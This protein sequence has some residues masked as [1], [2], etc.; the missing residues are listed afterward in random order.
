MDDAIFDWQMKYEDFNV[1]PYCP[2]H[3][4]R[5][6]Q[7]LR[8]MHAMV[9]TNA[10]HSHHQRTAPTKVTAASVGMLGYYKMD[11]TFYC[12]WSRLV[13]ILVFAAKLGWVDGEEERVECAIH[14]AR[15]SNSSQGCNH[16]AVVVTVWATPWAFWSGF[17]VRTRV[18]LVWAF[19]SLQ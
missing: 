5:V 14:F 18:F 15:P 12:P 2:C 3:L 7:G 16:L 1:T 10:P 9:S 6:S 19:Q 13:A 4:V 8:S 17:L 11:H